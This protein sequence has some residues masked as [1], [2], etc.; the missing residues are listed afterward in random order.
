LAAIFLRSIRY[1]HPAQNRRTDSGD[2][3]GHE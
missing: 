1:D 3:C 2:A